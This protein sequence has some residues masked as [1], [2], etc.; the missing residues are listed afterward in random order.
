MRVLARLGV[1]N[2]LL[3]N[4]AGG[5]HRAFRTGDLMVIRDHLN[6]MGANPLRGGPHFLDLTSLYE[7]RLPSLRGLRR[8]V[9]AGVAGPTYETP[10][11]TEMLRRL[12]ADAVGL[13][14]AYGRERRRAIELAA[15]EV[16]RT[17]R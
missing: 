4:A 11:E 14:T 12:G 15:V 17:R 16:L 5:I 2:L 6:L 13:S 8:G 7:S 10:A 9:Y 1:K 3:S